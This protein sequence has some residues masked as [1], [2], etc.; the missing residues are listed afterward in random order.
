M[1]KTIGYAAIT[2]AMLFI[3]VSVGNDLIAMFVKTKPKT[4]A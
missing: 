4:T 2:I 3:G 1:G